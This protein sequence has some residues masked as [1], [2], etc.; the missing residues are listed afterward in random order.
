MARTVLPGRPYALGAVWDGRGVNFSLFAADAT[1]VELCLYESD[2]PNARVEK[3]ALPDVLGHVWQ[4]YVSGV[5]PGQ[6]YA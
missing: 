5:R 6:L 2:A 3:L 4:G 1:K